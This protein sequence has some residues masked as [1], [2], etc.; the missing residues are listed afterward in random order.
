MFTKSPYNIRVDRSY[1][2]DP[3][4]IKELLLKYGTIIEN[5]FYG[6]Y[7]TIIL[8]LKEILNNDDTYKASVKQL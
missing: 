6:N 1:F 2:H 5:N 7:F 3:E 4:L 8:K